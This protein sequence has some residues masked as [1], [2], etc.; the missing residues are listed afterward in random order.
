M[1]IDSP[2]PERYADLRVGATLD[3]FEAG[4][5]RLV[6]WK[7]RLGGDLPRIAFACT[8]MRSNVEDMPGMVRMGHK[9]GVD[10]VVLQL[11]EP[12]LESLEPQMLWHHIPLT[13]RMTREA[14]ALAKELD[15]NVSLDMGLKHLLSAE[16]AKDGGGEGANEALEAVAV[17]PANDAR[18]KTL[19]EKC[20]YPWSS[21]LIDTDGDS[22]PCCW[23][24]Q[25]YGNMNKR[26]WEEIWNGA[27]VREIR[28]Q[29]LADTV[30]PGCRKKHC[31]V[32]M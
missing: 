4:V 14:L 7:K 6:E 13:A 32:D 25:S 24:G 12:E 30:P 11:M 17:D 29:F 27:E 16:A 10:Q 22:R 28:R 3:Q 23:A 1:S 31:R 19:V 26:T 8:F 18:G 9:W 21:L 2:D 20:R 15:V 5:G